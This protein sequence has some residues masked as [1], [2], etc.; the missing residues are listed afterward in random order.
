ME[1]EYS[2]LEK[3]LQRTIEKQNQRISTLML[4]LDLAQSQIQ[5]MKEDAEEDTASKKEVEAE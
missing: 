1:R 5:V 3:I 2:E 4:D